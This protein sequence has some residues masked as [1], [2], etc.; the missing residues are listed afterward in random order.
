[1]RTVVRDLQPGRVAEGWLHRGSFIG[2]EV[3]QKGKLDENIG[4]QGIQGETGKSWTTKTLL[5]VREAARELKVH[6]MQPL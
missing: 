6:T 1:M 2:G 5:V 3:G 4:C